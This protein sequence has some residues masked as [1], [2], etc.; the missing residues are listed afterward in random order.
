VRRVL[1][2]AAV[3]FAGCGPFFDGVGGSSNDIADA[4]KAGKPFRLADVTD[5]D[6]D[7]FYVVAPYSS[8][9]R[10]DRRLGFE[11]GKAE[12]SDYA[13]QDGGSLLIFVR[14][15]EVVH[16]FDQPGIEGDFSCVREDPLTPRQAVLRVKRGRVLPPGR[17]SR[18]CRLD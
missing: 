5:F 7:R 8:N 13:M 2:L 9:E 17:P 12:N 4:V 16:A 6:W 18:S 3:L 10:V 14:G 11:W 15:G 1:L